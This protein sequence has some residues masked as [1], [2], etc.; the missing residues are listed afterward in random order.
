[1]EILK[2]NCLYCGKEFEKKDSCSKKEWLFRKYCSKDCANKDKTGK[3]SWNKGLK[4]GLVPKTA[5]KKGEHRSIKTEFKK[6][7][8]ISKETKLRWKGRIPWNKGIH[9]TQIF[10]E[11]HPNWKGG[12]SDENKKIRHSLEIKLWR[13]SCF[14]RDNFT[15]QISGQSGGELQVHHINNFADF[16]EKRTEISNGITI[17]KELHLKFHSL[18]GRHNNTREQLEEF[19]NLYKNNKFS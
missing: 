6:G 2:K 7:M 18:Y 15:C 16:P 19:I 14:E 11:N 5:F 13:K 4:T 1:M 17:T 12:K 8:K 9:F 3:P 10:G